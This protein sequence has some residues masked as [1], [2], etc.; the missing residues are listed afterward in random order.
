MDRVVACSSLYSPK[1]KLRH[2]LLASG[3]S[4]A[5]AWQYIDDRDDLACDD[6]ETHG[7]VVRDFEGEG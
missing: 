2:Y 7:R 5:E 6:A 1:F 3:L 4:N